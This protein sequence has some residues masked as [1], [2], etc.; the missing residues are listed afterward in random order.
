MHFH[1]SLILF[2][3]TQRIT[4]SYAQLYPQNDTLGNLNILFPAVITDK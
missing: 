4:T 1:S 2:N 3:F